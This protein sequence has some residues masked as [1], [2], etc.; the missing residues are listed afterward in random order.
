MSV[1]AAGETTIKR[2]RAS[3]VAGSVRGMPMVAASDSVAANTRSI[4]RC[5]PTTYC[6][7]HAVVSHNLDGSGSTRPGVHSDALRR[8]RRGK[9]RRE[10]EDA[11]ILRRLSTPSFG[12]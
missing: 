10:I 8:Q 3:R 9:A 11:W 6:L 2:T 5:G 1:V 4:N 12:P 7:T